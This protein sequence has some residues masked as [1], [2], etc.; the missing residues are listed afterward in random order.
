[1][2]KLCEAGEIAVNEYPSLD[3]RSLRDHARLLAMGWLITNIALSIADLPLRYLLKDHLGLS[4]AGVSLFFVIGN[5]TNYIK[6]IAGM[7]TDAIPFM[8][9]RRRHYLLLGV[10]GGGLFWVLLGAVPRT[11][12]SLLFTYTLFYVT[13]VLTSTS[14]GGRMVEVS[15]EYLAAGR[16]T[17]QRIGTFRI[18]AL[19]GGVVGGWLATK[20]FGLTVGISASLHFMLFALLYRH[21]KE[22][23]TARI[24]SSFLGDVSSIFRKLIGS[25]VLMSA[26]GMVILIAA[27]P[28]FG[29]PLFFYQ[30]NTLHFS[31]P[32]VGFLTS[33][34]AG[35]GLIGAWI[36]Y[37]TCRRLPVQVLLYACV[38]V[39]ALGTITFLSYHSHASAIVITGLAGITGTMTILPV[40]DLAARATPSGAEAIGYAVMMSVWN[41]TNAFSDWTG[42]KLF[43]R[44]KLTFHSL[45]W[46]N[47]GTTA[48]VLFVIPLLPAALLRAKDGD[49]TVV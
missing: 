42:S 47:A 45:V 3:N 41:F 21:M 36:Y 5:F 44:W 22:P 34:N 18:A 43:D 49:A 13:V 15:R 31:K 17:A 29:T 19:T 27:S 8:G 37:A 4:A 9:T 6:P 7:F 20:T 30:T 48:L 38:V 24:S 10:G 35:F 12:H 25:R 1:L 2:A 28:G 23:P 33:W 40:Y 26:A 32:F 16:L 14:L 11:Y 46:L 39:H